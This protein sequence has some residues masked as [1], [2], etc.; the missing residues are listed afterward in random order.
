MKRIYIYFFIALFVFCSCNNISEDE[1]LI[2]IPSAI[3]KRNVLVEEFT[4]QRCINCPNAANTLHD[5]Q[6]N[7]S[8]NNVIVVSIHGGNLAVA[9]SSKT[10][11]F[12]TKLADLYY[13]NYNKPLLP[14]AIINKQ[15]GV[16]PQAQW[17]SEIYNKLQEETNT[18]IILNCTIK[19]S[20]L[21]IATTIKYND[22]TKQNAKLQLWLVEDSVVAPQ[23]FPNNIIK[24][25]YL[26]NNIL[27][28]AINGTSGQD[29]V[30]EHNKDNIYNNKIDI[31]TAY[32][33]NNLHVVAFVYN[34]NG[35]LQVS[36]LKINK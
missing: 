4:G 19:N 15:G 18:N 22:E 5:I 9:N 25:D 3:I 35:V 6:K 26:H 16:L 30:L 7:Y 17:A 10:V 2:D 13:N 21:S 29:I 27:R 24:K 32:N 31:N 34:N 33:K 28:E 36:K 23:Q 8:S 12:R 20:T 11:G 1:R 14:S